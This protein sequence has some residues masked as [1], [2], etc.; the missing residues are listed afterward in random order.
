[1]LLGL[2]I[3]RPRICG[4]HPVEAQEIRI[5]NCSTSSVALGR[6]HCKVLAMSLPTAADLD[7]AEQWAPALMT[8]ALN[9]TVDDEPQTVTLGVPN[10]LLCNFRRPIASPPLRL[11]AAELFH[12]RAPNS[13]Q[14]ALERGRILAFTF[15]LL[16]LLS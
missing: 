1:M 7:V 15:H 10:R 9:A 14:Y 5:Y 13:T 2:G 12:R 3:G 16:P 8:R 11:D 6:N 4:P